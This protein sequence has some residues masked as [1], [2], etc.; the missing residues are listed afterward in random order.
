MLRLTVKGGDDLRATSL[1]LRRAKGNLRKNLT[2]AFRSAGEQTLREVK[3]AIETN[4]L[5][6]YRTKGK[7][8]TA[9]M[10]GTHI[11]HR[12]AAVTRME[13]NTSS[14]P[15]VRFVVYNDRLGDARRVPWHIDTGKVFRHPIMGK[16]RDG[17]WRGGAGMS[18]KPWFY[19]TIKKDVR[20][21]EAKCDDAI[22]KT[23]REI[24]RS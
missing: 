5:R 10:P 7:R 9:H 12:I 4:P 21:F 6:G 16:N 23:I 18:G 17:S 1:A 2:A 8:F 24:E 11:R 15:H 14:D 19:S 20:V 22:D 3:R 13:V